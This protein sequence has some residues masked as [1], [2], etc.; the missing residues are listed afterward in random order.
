MAAKEPQLAHLYAQLCRKIVCGI[1]SDVVENTLANG[2]P[3]RLEGILV[4][5][6]LLET[7]QNMFEGIF[8][9]AMPADAESA[10]H[11]Q[12][13]GAKRHRLGVGVVRFINE[14]YHYGLVDRV[15]IR[16]CTE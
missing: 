15:I 14:L 9:A 10:E 16:H 11:R 7:C 1:T 3:T 12:A 2:T 4:Y 5:G 8:C 13:E 6:L